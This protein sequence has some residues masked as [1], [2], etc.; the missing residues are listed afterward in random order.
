MYLYEA[1][2]SREVIFILL[3]GFNYMAI[4]INS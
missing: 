4:S 2:F 3:M 1:L